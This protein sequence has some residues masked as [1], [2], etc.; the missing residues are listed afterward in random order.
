MLHLHLILIVRENSYIR[1]SRKVVKFN[2]CRK[3]EAG[4]K[5]RKDTYRTLEKKQAS[6]RDS[7]LAGDYSSA[8][9]LYFLFK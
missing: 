7:P 5:Y 8:L 4:K 3:Q 1:E 2:S 9:S 6:K